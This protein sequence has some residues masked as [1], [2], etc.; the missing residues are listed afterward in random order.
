MWTGGVV[1]SGAD[2]FRQIYK[3]PD[4]DLPP[5]KSLLVKCT[6]IATRGAA[7]WLTF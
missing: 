3:L 6:C 1:Q 2:T 4:R 5:Y 7:R